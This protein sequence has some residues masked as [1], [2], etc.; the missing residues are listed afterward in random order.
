MQRVPRYFASLITLCVLTASVI[1]QTP[2]SVGG[3]ILIFG[4]VY[5]PDGKPASRVKVFLE[6]STGMLRDTVCDD[7]GNYDFRSVTAGRYRL[8]AT[9]PDAPEQFSDPAESDSTRSFAN[10]VQIHV[11]L[12]LPLENKKERINAGVIHAN[13]AAIPKSARKAFEQGVKSRQENRPQQAIAQF[14]QALEIYPRYFQALT[15]RG[16]L[17]MEQKQ[18][19]QAK[20]DFEQALQINEK[21]A[22]ALRG[23]GYCELQ[24]QQFGPAVS[25][26]ERAFA[27]EPNVPL[28]L[29]LLGYGN[30]S[31]G[32][33]EAAKQCLYE[34]LRQDA[35]GTSRAHVYLGEIFAHE[36]NFKAAA[37][38]VRAYLKIK[39]EA[40]DAAQ[41]QKLESEWRKNADRLPQ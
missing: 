33:Y 1:A 29:L 19:V 37:D 31:L 13:E 39:P 10:R 36:K 32:H 7:N 27:L 30:L 40:A 2:P 23:L 16:T 24:E 26:L 20:A 11:Y 38:E 9:N 14:N 21:Y 34:A 41:L 8:K 12:R 5:L 22:A 18:L 28:T 6:T 35:V 3:G 25:H 15:E 17:L 4:R